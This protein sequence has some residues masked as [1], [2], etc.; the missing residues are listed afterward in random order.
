MNHDYARPSTGAIRYDPAAALPP[1]ATR[2]AMPRGLLARTVLALL[3]SLLLVG[4]YALATAIGA[5]EAQQKQATVAHIDQLLDA[6]ASTA[7]VACHNR[8]ASLAG[9]IVRGLLRNPA[10]RAAAIETD[11]ANLARSDGPAVPGTH[12]ARPLRLPA[13]A[14][15]VVGWLRVTADPDA[16]ARVARPE[17]HFIVLQIAGQL[18]LAA[19]TVTTVMLVVVVRPLRTVADGVRRLDPQ[20]GDHLPVP[21]GHA[22][23]EIG[24]LAEDIN[25]L[26]DACGRERVQ[27]LAT[28][29]DARKYHSIFDHAETGLF[30]CTADGTLASWNPAFARLMNIPP[31]DPGRDGIALRHLAWRDPAAVAELVLQC[32][33]VNRA[34]ADD[35]AMRL[36]N[37]FWR[38]L[39]VVLVPVGEGQ[40]QGVVH[41]VTE[42]K[43]AEA[44]AHH[45]A[46]TDRLTGAAN[47]LGLEEK[48]DR[49][50]ADP[51]VAAAGITLI[52]VDLDNF[53]RINEGYGLP[54]GDALLKECCTR[55]SGCVDRRDTLAR[56]AGDRFALALANLG[57]DD[58]GLVAERV[59]K[60]MAR[61]FHVDG[62]PLHL[63][64][65]VGIA[66]HP[67][68]GADL[69]ALLRCAE[70]ALGQAK[71]GGG[72]A[73]VAYCNALVEAAEQR[74]RLET[75]LR[76]AIQE[77]EFQLYYQPV[78]DLAG[79]R[80][81]GAEA[82]I[83]W[84]HPERGLVAPATF[85][86]LAEETDLIDAIGLW[87][88]DAACR[89]LATWEAQGL[90]RYLSVNV[91][92]HQI[93]DGLTPA[94]LAAAVERHGV[95]PARLAIEITEGVLLADSECVRDWLEAVRA[96]GFPIFLDDFG[97]GYSSLSYLR[98]LPISTVKVDQSFVRDMEHDDSDRALVKAVLA[99]AHGL[100]LSVIADGVETGGQLGL[101]R[102]MRC[103]RVQGYHFS[104]PVPAERF[105][106]V[107]NRI[108]SL[109]AHPA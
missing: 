12:L 42:L 106:A 93:P 17:V 6:V 1:A 11:D 43:E 102:D 62:S 75:D 7:A 36:D 76:A 68:D 3:A 40:L 59:L 81:A 88:I 27:R 86:P 109:L 46:V 64:A 20:S 41:D 10:V 72:N 60:A 74:R 53:K 32:R 21:G 89:Q 24:H 33:L 28:E 15:R 55:L 97:T 30:I 51:V 19:L 16:I 39:K 45:R 104:T 83:R 4:G 107:A 5:I 56:L 66:R 25:R 61:P 57:G 8:D 22:G 96:Q 38:W 47:R 85:I 29:L 87:A 71:A 94:M 78:V 103:Q 58:P 84:P 79:N 49:L 14:D 2:A 54:A 31:R 67:R 9:E 34:L 48:L 100:G 50:L 37:G 98:R 105:E 80:L 26:V 77:G 108:D 95:A 90:D 92:G 18:V 82:L 91:S 101:L 63:H 73:F 35:L 69:P 99:M 44:A 23:T 13:E 52:L 70:L 65:S